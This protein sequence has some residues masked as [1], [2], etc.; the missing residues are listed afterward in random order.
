ME[1]QLTKKEKKK[2]FD[3]VLKNQAKS[4]AI[5]QCFL[6]YMQVVSLSD[7]ASIKGKSKR[8]IQYRSK[9]LKGISISKRRFVILSQ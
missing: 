7:Y 3:L 6:D 9:K 8:T 1:Q 5:T 2:I 4:C